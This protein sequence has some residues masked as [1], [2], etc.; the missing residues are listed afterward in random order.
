MPIFI[1]PQQPGLFVPPLQRYICQRQAFDICPVP[2]RFDQSGLLLLTMS[3][4]PTQFTL[5]DDT[6]SLPRIIHGPRVNLQAALLY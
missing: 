6:R 3:R 5:N 2:Q 1:G 4:A